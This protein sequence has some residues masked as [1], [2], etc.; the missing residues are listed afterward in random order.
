MPE[1]CKRSG[2]PLPSAYPCID[3]FSSPAPLLAVV[4]RSEVA[5]GPGVPLVPDVVATAVVVGLV[6]FLAL[7]LYQMRRR[8]DAAA[9]ELRAVQAHLRRE[10]SAREYAEQLHRRT[11]ERYR[12][13]AD[14]V[15]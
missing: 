13:P 11:E 12:T 9:E 6:V 10:V 7:A 14:Q 8:A 4:P 1:V 15:K 5:T 2:P 3:Q